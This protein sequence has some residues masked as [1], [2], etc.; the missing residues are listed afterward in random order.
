MLT[1]D[2]HNMKLKL[3]CQHIQC[4][5]E[6]FLAITY[7]LQVLLCIVRKAQPHF[8]VLLC[9]HCQRSGENM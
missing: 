1:Y 8:P 4:G 6:R 5:C 3:L 9:G 2:F 7:Q